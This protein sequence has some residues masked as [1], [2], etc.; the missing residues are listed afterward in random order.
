MPQKYCLDMKIDYS[1]IRANAYIAEQR[2]KPKAKISI[3]AYIE[4]KILQKSH[5]YT[6]QIFSKEGRYAGWF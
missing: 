1:H 6:F 5:S 2:E 3:Q 4:Q